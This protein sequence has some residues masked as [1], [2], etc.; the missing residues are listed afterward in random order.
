MLTQQSLPNH[1]LMLLKAGLKG[2]NYT[3]GV[4]P[5]LSMEPLHLELGPL[6][7]KKIHSYHRLVNWTDSETLHPC[8]LHILA[9]PLHLLLMSRADFPFKLLGLI[10]I[11]NQIRQFCPVKHNDKLHFSCFLTDIQRHDKGW[12]FTLQSEVRVKNQLCW[13]A[14]SI[15]LFQDTAG[16]RGQKTGHATAL[17]PACGAPLTWQLGGNLGRRYAYHS[18]DFNP[19]HLSVLSARAFGLKRHI[20]HGMFSKA[21]CISTLHQLFPDYFKEAFS[22]QT[23]FIKPIF[24][25]AKVSFMHSDKSDKVVDGQPREIEFS[26]KEFETQAPHLNGAL[27]LI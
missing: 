23:K 21:R 8:L 9:F 13:Q 16:Q 15:N 4:T 5:A 7:A 2:N 25:P 12:I 10:H 6:S 17:K 11:S 26:L 18:G 19:I 14:K 1:F 22:V 27:Q 3:P 24:L 20:A